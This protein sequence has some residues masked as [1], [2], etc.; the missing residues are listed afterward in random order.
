MPEKRICLISTLAVLL[1]LGQ[2]SAAAAPA[3]SLQIY[4]I[5]VEGGGATLVIAP[6]GESLL[7]DS[8]NAPPNAERDTK[9]I[10]AAMQL[11]GL[12][13][14]DHLFI[15]HYDTDHAGG[16]AAL[17][18][19]TSIGK[20]VD[21]GDMDNAWFQNPN[22]EERWKNYLSA[23]S[24]KRMIV[25]PGDIVPLK[26]VRVQVVSSNGE[27]LAKPINSGG[28]NPYCDDAEQKE[29]D[30]SENSRSAGLLLSFGKFKFLDVGDLTWDKEMALAC[31]VN[32][33]GR[34]SLYQATHHGF[35]HDVSG[36]TAHI[37]AIQPQVVV[38]N[39]GP[40]KGFDGPSKYEKLA[41]I[42]GIEGIWQ[43]HLSLF[44]DQDH[45][46]K[47]DMIANLEP[48]DQ[49]Q[50]HWIKVVVESSGKF[51]VTNGRN[52]FSQSYQAH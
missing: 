43:G 18:K 4:F 38:V 36:A 29:P 27:V 52:G 34:V 24:G 16:V 47:E 15:T 17:A 25:K 21:H 14:L 12:K 50:G 40:R 28:A 22:Y 1:S 2:V 49:C 32:K 8:G 42:P 41:K 11:A 23:A 5:D 39:N 3:P 19:L 9:R 6:S 46:T 20:F 37:R 7:I 30:K 33:L 26:G 35:W 45:N 48:S 10:Y 13:K 44:N 51:T 31:P